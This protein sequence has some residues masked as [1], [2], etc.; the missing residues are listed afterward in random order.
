MSTHGEEIVLKSDS[1]GD[2]GVK[3]IADHQTLRILDSGTGEEFAVLVWEYQGEGVYL[4]PV[5]SGKASSANDGTPWVFA[6]EREE[7]Q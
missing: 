6:P 2:H 1:I 7:D 4:C 3:I 5:G